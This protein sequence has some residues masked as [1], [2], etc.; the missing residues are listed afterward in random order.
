MISADVNYVSCHLKRAEVFAL[1]M[2]DI[3]Y[4]AEKKPK[5]NVNLKI[6]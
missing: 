3:Q 4:E 5:A 6:V 2:K 1:S